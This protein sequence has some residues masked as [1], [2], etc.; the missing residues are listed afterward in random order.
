MRVYLYT[1]ILYTCI[2]LCLRKAFCLIRAAFAPKVGV[3]CV[4]L[5][6]AIF[7]SGEIIAVAQALELLPVNQAY[8]HAPLNTEVVIVNRSNYEKVTLT[9]P[10]VLN[11]LFKLNADWIVNTGKNKTGHTEDLPCHLTVFDCMRRVW[12]R[13]Y[14]GT[15]VKDEFG[16]PSSSILY[17]Q[18]KPE[19]LVE[20][21]SIMPEANDGSQSILRNSGSSF[22]CRG[23]LFPRICRLAGSVSLDGHRPSG[24]LGCISSPL[25]PVRC[26]LV[27]SLGFVSGVSRKVGLSFSGVS[28]NLSGI[29]QGSRGFVRPLHFAQLQGNQNRA[30]NSGKENTSGKPDINSFDLTQFGKSLGLGCLILAYAFMYG[31]VFCFYVRSRGRLRYRWFRA[32][33]LNGVGRIGRTIVATLFFA[34]SL[35]FAFQGITSLVAWAIDGYP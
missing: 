29:Y 30:D 3:L 32:L 5:W 2:R 31:A 10:D 28:L 13:A 15:I 24:V 6:I 34:I 25:S 22:G 27:Q 12:L 26:L 20:Y 35:I 7:R 33:G 8:R 16:R 11:S 19:F 17:K 21:I 9:L 4:L 23:E 1:C 14:E 18:S